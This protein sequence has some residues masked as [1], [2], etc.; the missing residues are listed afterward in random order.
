M[1]GID[2]ELPGNFLGQLQVLS[3]KLVQRNAEECAE[4][5]DR[6]EMLHGFLEKLLAKKEMLKMYSNIY[7]VVIRI[8][9]HSSQ[10]Q[11]YFFINQDIL[12]LIGELDLPI[13][14]SVFSW[15]GV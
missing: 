14:L 6:L 2:G 9:L 12:K 5:D 4:G 1:A 10:A 3:A 13:E 8:F 15:G 7:D 11:M